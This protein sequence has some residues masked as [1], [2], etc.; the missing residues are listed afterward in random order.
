[1]IADALPEIRGARIAQLIESD[2]P[3]GAERTVINLASHLQA[4]GCYSLVILPA[5]GEGWLGREAAAAGLP[6]ERFDLDRPVS[7]K[8]ARWL[9]ATLRRHGI[10]LAH[11]HEFTMAV[12]GAWAAWRTG[13]GHVATMHG[14]RY[15]AARLRRRLAL[16]AAVGLGGRLVAVSHQLANHLSRDLW[17][18]RTRIATVPN[19]VRWSPASPAGIRSAL[20]LA[21]T[22]RLILA[23]GN[24]Y[25]VK[26]HEHLIEALGQIARRH[27]GAHVAIAGRGELE[28]RLRARAESLGVSAR[29]HFLG[30][31]SDVSA[32]LAAADL[33]ALPS[34]SEGLPLSLLEAMFAARP[35]VASDVGDVRIVLDGGE[36]GLLVEPGSSGQ[37]ALAL[38]WLL[39]HPQE[40]RRMGEAAARRAAADY[41]V[42]SMVARYAGVYQSVLPAPAAQRL[43]STRI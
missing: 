24:L 18:G 40:A 37:L 10:T 30:L 33:F 42:S 34:L 4:Q 15:Y 26:G 22:D 17:I 23:V 31:R 29:V 19:G 36:T 41:D 14:G 35:I 1:M 25:P 39:S 3:G 20:G 12:Y 13:I 27:P 28:A 38:E 6:I 8:C 32:L 9:G 21:T 11:S 16:R 5:R 2:G 7:P 43:V